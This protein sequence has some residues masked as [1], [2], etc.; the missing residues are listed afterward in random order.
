M[1]ARRIFHGFAFLL[2]VALPI[3]QGCGGDD[4]AVNGDT[5]DGGGDDGT[6][7]GDGSTSSD[8]NTN[9]DTGTTTDAFCTALNDYD[10]RCSL[11]DA[12]S[13]AEAAACTSTEANASPQFLAAYEACESM[14]PCPSPGASTD[15]GQAAYDSCLQA[16]FG[17]P[18]TVAQQLATDFC[19][20]C[21][22]ASGSCAVG[23]YGDPKAARLL[24]LDDAI[25]GE[26]DDN[27]AKSDAG[28]RGDG[29]LLS[30]SD[31]FTKC[32][33]GIVLAHDPPPA[34]CNDL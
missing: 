1:R 16:H 9:T 11:T 6:T 15:G 3:A 24:E 13:V 18:D 5:S 14:Q 30:C 31:E 2:V 28:I 10:T 34:A 23:F 12:C 7:G 19:T 29:G 4:S 33:R 22:P 26:I 32:V 21:V 17:S 27:C 20:R 8:G 25:L